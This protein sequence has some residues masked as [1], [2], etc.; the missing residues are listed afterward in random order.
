MGDGELPLTSSRLA[1]KSHNLSRGQ[2]QG[3]VLEYFKAR[4]AGVAERG[5]E[6][7]SQT[8]FLALTSLSP[9]TEAGSHGAV[10]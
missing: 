8:R 3:E 10:S 9:L 6:S 7:P 5:Q 4:A 2:R 1:H